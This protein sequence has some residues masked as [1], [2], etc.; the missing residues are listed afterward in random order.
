MTIVRPN[1]Y[2]DFPIIGDNSELTRTVIVKIHG[3]TDVNA[4]D[5]SWTGDNYVIADDY[6]GYLSE[7]PV[8]DVVPAQILAKLRES[9]CLFFGYTMRDW[10]Q[11]VFLHR[12][13]PGNRF[14]VTP[15]YWAVKQ[16][17]DAFK[18]Q[19]WQMS[20]VSLYRNRLADYVERLDS[21]LREHRHEL[22]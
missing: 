16:D 19:F 7:R 8:E 11:R 9:N 12:I 1:V 6:I 3:T 14:G 4:D 15:T 13:W 2:T 20:G 10:T 18:Q 22:M 21:Y 17:A 5:Y